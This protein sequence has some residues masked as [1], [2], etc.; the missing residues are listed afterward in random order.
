MEMCELSNGMNFIWNCDIMA[1]LLYTGVVAWI[2]V[3]S[4]VLYILYE[5]V[6]ARR[7]N[8]K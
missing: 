8:A 4:W 6:I 3:F 7:Q 1:F 2:F 5:H